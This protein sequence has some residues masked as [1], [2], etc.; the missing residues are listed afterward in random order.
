MEARYE[1][2]RLANGVTVAT[3]EQPHMAS[4]SLGLWVA[5]GSR[6]EPEAL[7]GACHF[8]EHMV[9]K[10][11]SSR[12]AR[13]ISQEVE[14][15]GGYLN[16]FTT[17]ENTCYHARAPHQSLDPLLE[18]LVDMT[19][20]SKFK[21]A[22]I[23]KERGV[24]K[25]EIAMYL[26]EPSQHVQELLN[27]LVWP[28]HAL[29]RPLA[30]TEIVLDRMRRRELVGFHGQS[31]VGPA[32]LIVAAGRVTHEELLRSAKRH[33]SYFVE[34][35]LPPC[36]LVDDRQDG[37]R[38]G[39][40]TKATEQT[41]VALGIR[42]CNRHDERR[43][44]LRLL[45]TVLGEIM[46]SRL[47]DVIREQHG[48]AYSISSSLGLLDDTGLLTISAGLDAENLPRVLRLVMR[49]LRRLKD[50]APGPS[51]MRRIR[52]YALA[53]FELGLE[54]TENQMTL[55]GEQLI[56]YRRAPDPSE[57]KRQLAAVTGAQI[58][59]CARAFFQS[60]NY[61]L[62][63]VSPLEKFSAQCLEGH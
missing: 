11:T 52:D 14:G 39:L 63:M 45:N 16:A 1:V 46:S 42:V 4:V 27:E 44:A 51:E 10:G 60:R 13:D 55:L 22:D 43:F 20:R 41:Q 49:E 28:N 15:L 48:L 47:F 36:A 50:R 34:R 29:G 21:P 19:V 6:H 38:V 26:D 5:V 59:A 32:I 35:P 37:P 53:Q 8:I 12:S 7:N 33:A 31:Y 40:F 24:I 56:G 2:T 30:G 9:F 61:N 25:E 57:T 23:A 3:A 58:R 18:I 17:E 54:S 62:A